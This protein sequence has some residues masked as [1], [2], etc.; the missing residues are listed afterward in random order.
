MNRGRL[1]TRFVDLSGESL[2]IAKRDLMQRFLHGIHE[3]QCIGLIST[4]RVNTPTVQP[5]FDEMLIGVRL[6][7]EE[8]RRVS[9]GIRWFR[10]IFGRMQDNVTS[11]A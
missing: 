8:H 5:E 7:R 9:A 2:Q 3:A 4:L 6:R 11:H 10:P 1:Q